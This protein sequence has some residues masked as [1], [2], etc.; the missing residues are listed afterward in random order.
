MVVATLA[1]VGVFVALYLTLFKVGIIGEM[2]CTIGSCETVQLSKW[3]AFMGL[4]VA[5]W[6]LAFYVATLAVAL[7]GVRESLAASRIISVA[8]VLMSGWGVVFSLYLTYLEL[9]VID[10]IC[11]W[12]VVSAVIV[13]LIFVASVADLREH[14]K[15]TEE[16]NERGHS[17]AA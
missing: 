2:T 1:L 6:G 4:P 14:G 8:L 13:L 7:A 15:A 11:M 10:A 3:S 9:F 5:A 16:L 17:P 12:C